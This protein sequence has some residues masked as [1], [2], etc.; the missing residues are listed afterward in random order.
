MSTGDQRD[1]QPPGFRVNYDCRHYSGY[2][3]CRLNPVCEGCEKYDP[4][5]RRVLI[6]KLGAMG[7]VLRTTPILSA[8]RAEW[9]DAHVTWVTRPE[10]GDLL[11]N[12]PLIDR[13]LTWGHEASLT[14]QAIEFDVVLNFEKEVAALALGE[15]IRAREL[16]GFRLTGAGTVGI[17]DERAGHAL[18]LGLDDELKF[19]GNTRVHQ[20]IT[21]E[22][23][24]LPWDGRLYLFEPDAASLVRRDALL[25]EHPAL[26][27]MTVVGLNTGC[28]SGFPTK[29]WSEENIDALIR[30][31]CNRPS[32]AVLL[33]GGEREAEMNRRISER[34]MDR[35]I[36][37][38]CD[39]SPD[40]FVGL[41]MACDAIVSADSLPM[42]L[43]IALGR[44]VVALFGPTSA[45]EVEVGRLGEKIIA[46]IECSPCYLT[47][48]DKTSD[49]HPLCMDQTGAEL[50]AAALE[51]VLA[52]DASRSP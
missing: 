25:D 10:S 52:R 41:L 35:L 42:H 18:R 11:K 34:F 40:D 6:I 45:T 23:V 48:C 33:L 16:R 12:N 22:M 31:L 15:T 46:E 30:L 3:P 2:R 36:D 19:R 14:L 49:G 24:G 28:G 8:V 43:G 4:V 29:Q 27:E 37:G 7:D 26:A 50:V 17:A 39:N 20:Q 47:V 51:R 1:V 9:P 13:L 38:G 5:G 21:C 44:R 32:T